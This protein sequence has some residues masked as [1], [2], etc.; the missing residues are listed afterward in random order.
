MPLSPDHGERLAGQEEGGHAEEEGVQRSPRAGCLEG[1][2]RSK[3]VH[4][5]QASCHHSAGALEG[6]NS[7]TEV[8]LIMP[9]CL[10]LCCV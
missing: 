6:Q 5:A 9:K 8:L 4:L 3:D 10:D 7:K 1:L 2:C